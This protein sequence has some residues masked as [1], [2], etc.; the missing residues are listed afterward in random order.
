MPSGGIPASDAK[1][2]VGRGTFPTREVSL[3]PAAPKLEED[4]TTVQN[5]DGY[6]AVAALRQARRCQ[7]ML[8]NLEEFDYRHHML[9]KNPSLIDLKPPIC[10]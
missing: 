2:M 8:R 10:L 6:R 1:K 3:G 7:V 9:Q 4:L 5:P